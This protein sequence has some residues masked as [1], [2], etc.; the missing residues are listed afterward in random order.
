MRNVYCVRV[1]QWIR[2]S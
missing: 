2:S 1:Q